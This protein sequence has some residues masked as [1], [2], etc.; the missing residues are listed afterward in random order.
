MKHDTMPAASPGTSEPSARTDKPL[1]S[2]RG[3]T[4]H[5]GAAKGLFQSKAAPV[6]RAVDGLD[7]DIWKGE[8]LGVVG[9]SGCGKSTTGRL[10]IRL[11]EATA[12]KVEYE[13]VDLLTMPR[14]QM[15]ARRRD[16]SI[17]FQDPFASLNPRMNV[18]TIIGEPLD[19]HGVGLR[20]DRARR[21]LEL[22]DLVGLPRAYADRYPHEF[23]GGQRQRIGIARALAL[24]PR[25]VVC[26]EAVS[27]LD[28]SVQAQII[29]LLS[30]LQK[31][32]GLTYLFISHNL[33]VV[34]HI[35]DR[36]AVM[37]LGKIVE[38]APKRQLYA[39][40]RHPYTQALLSAI[41][42]AKVGVERTRVRL[43]GDIPSPVNPP[44]G[45]RFHTRCP[46]AQAI[47]KEVEP[48]MRTLD[49]QHEAACHFA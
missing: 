10:L 12:G 45:C 32:R 25:F 31:E 48:P 41:P 43:T 35:A 22:M 47:C 13:G 44:S 33:A 26:D 7:F 18:A 17:V 46:M 28:V 24:E 37:Y 27:A 19:I 20:A 5:F 11:L 8:T 39:T 4:K 49:T 3:L 14:H 30:E 1:L 38:L 42:V 16:L 21:V 6:V 2:V 36:V 29:N 34:R 23:S 40:P 15:Q 9:E